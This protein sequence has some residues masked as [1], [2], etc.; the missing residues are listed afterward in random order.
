[1]PVPYLGNALNGWVHKKIVRLVTKQVVDFKVV[2]T[3]SD[4]ELYIN[5][6]P[7]PSALVQRM[8]QEQRT[9][10]WW[11]IIIKQGPLLT[12]DDEIVIDN[13]TYRIQQTS[14]WSGSGFQKYKAVEDYTDG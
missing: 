12:T 5:K 8:P 6:Q 13:I 4:I 2:E 9:W 14:N 1:M 11:S 10:K 7:V 3:T